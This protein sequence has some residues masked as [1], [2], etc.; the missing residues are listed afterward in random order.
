MEDNDSLKSSLSLNSTCATLLHENLEDFLSAANKK[1]LQLKKENETLQDKVKFFKSAKMKCDK[2]LNV[3]SSFEH[4]LQPHY[5]KVKK[6][7]Y[8]IEM[9]FPNTKA[10]INYI[11]AS[12]GLQINNID[13]FLNKNTSTQP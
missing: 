7:L 2:C 1:V 10:V 3:Y 8:I 13:K 9:K 6:Q 12:P 4:L 11:K 5:V